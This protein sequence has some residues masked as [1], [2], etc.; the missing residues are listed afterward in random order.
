MSIIL[1][2]KW[3]ILLTKLLNS[4]NLLHASIFDEFLVYHSDHGLKE[5]IP[6]HLLSRYHVI[7]DPG[8]PLNGCS[9]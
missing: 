6:N 2:E 1:S 9:S 8:V 5:V 7:L 3:K 4:F